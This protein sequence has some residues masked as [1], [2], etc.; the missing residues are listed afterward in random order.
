MFVV[1]QRVLNGESKTIQF[2]IVQ[3]DFNEMYVGETKQGQG[4]L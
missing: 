4:L 2:K 3:Y 1:F